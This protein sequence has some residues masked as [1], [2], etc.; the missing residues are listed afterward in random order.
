MELKTGSWTQVLR[1]EEL[2][3]N[4]A[5][6]FGQNLIYLKIFLTHNNQTNFKNT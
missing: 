5:H 3:D 1:S 4:L 2:H 6:H